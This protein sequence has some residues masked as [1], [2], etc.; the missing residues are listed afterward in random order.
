MVRT[1]FS[2]TEIASVL[3]N[4]GFR[5]AGRTG[6]HLKLRYENPKTDE[7]RIVTVPMK[8]EDEIGTGTLHSI[9]EQSGANDFHAWCRWIDENR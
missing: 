2:G 6:S 9:A 3:Q 1:S 8:S 5:P 4:H 7:V